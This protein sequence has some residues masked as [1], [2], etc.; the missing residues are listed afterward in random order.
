MWCPLAKEASGRLFMRCS[1]L[2]WHRALDSK[3]WILYDVRKGTDMDGLHLLN[4]QGS[5][6]LMILVGMF[7]K[8]RGIVDGAAQ[9]CLTDLCIQVV[10]PCNILKS[11][12][13]KLDPSVLRACGILLVVAVLLILVCMGLNR[14]LFNHY[15]GAQKKVLQYCTLI[16]NGGFLGNAVAE[17]VYGLTGLLYASMYLI[18]MRIIMWSAGTS[19]FIAQENNRKQVLRNIVTHPC[20]VAVYIG[21]VRMLLDLPVPTL[22]SSTIATIGSCNTALTMFIIGMILSDVK[23]TT[24]FTRTTLWLST[25]RLVLLPLLVWLLCQGMGLEPVATGVAVLM[26]GMPAGSTAAIFAARYNSDAEFA[27]K[28]VVLSTLL[29]MVTIPV[30][31][32]LIG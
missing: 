32:M 28:C 4:L 27:S 12:F 11:Y 21:M 20:L 10:I 19:Y 15:E 5:L 2:G 26:T 23:L 3:N 6:F 17:G 31:C 1:T 22:L 8:R 18:P 14:V 24:L 7:L 16:S 25:L 30:W 9:R 29:S 13:V